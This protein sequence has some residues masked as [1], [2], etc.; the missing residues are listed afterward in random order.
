MINS[1]GHRFLIKSWHRFFRTYTAA[2]GVCSSQLSHGR[3]KVHGCF[4][5]GA[6]C[7][8]G[9]SGSRVGQG[10]SLM[11][12]C[13][14]AWHLQGWSRSCT[15]LRGHCTLRS[16]IWPR[17]N[18]WWFLFSISIST[19]YPG[20]QENHCKKALLIWNYSARA[21]NN[22]LVLERKYVCKSLKLTITLFP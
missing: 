17:S 19:L 8:R 2:E 4:E 21:E 5:P 7:L 13:A 3:G 18:G 6:G 10:L 1:Q 9:H 15:T 12:S 20:I 11:S 16:T 14:R 22:A